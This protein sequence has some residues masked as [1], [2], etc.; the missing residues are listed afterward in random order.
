M[1]KYLLLACLLPFFTITFSQESIGKQIEIKKLQPSQEAAGGTTI[2]ADAR[3]AVSDSVMIARLDYRIAAIKSK[4]E[5]VKADQ[6]M[7]ERATKD[8]WFEQMERHIAQAEEK[9]KQLSNK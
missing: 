6:E 9:K 7:F 8:G 5:Y 3:P 1:K 4:M 2:H